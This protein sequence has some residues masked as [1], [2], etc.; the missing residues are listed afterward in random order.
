MTIWTEGRLSKCRVRVSIVKLVLC[1]P[2]NCVSYFL[3]IAR[4]R[5]PFEG[6]SILIFLNDINIPRS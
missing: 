5:V 1:F 4:H 3:E 2:F 6:I